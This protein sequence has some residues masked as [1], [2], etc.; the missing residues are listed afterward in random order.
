MDGEA[1]QPI[2]EGGHKEW[3]TTGNRDTQAAAD[4][5]TGLTEPDNLSKLANLVFFFFNL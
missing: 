4:E 3:D 2:V 1:W 5:N